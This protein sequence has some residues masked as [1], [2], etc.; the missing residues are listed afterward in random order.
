MNN[1]KQL[2]SIILSAVLTV[3]AI[4]AFAYSDVEEGSWYEKSVENASEKG[5]FAGYEDGTF[6]PE[7]PVS[8]A[9]LAE[10]LTRMDSGKKAE[11]TSSSQIQG[12]ENEMTEREKMT[13]ETYNR[14]FDGADIPENISESELYSIVNKVIYGDIYN[15]STLD[16][17]EREMISLTVLTANGTLTL[18]KSH[19]YSALNAGLSADEITETLYQ[20]TPYIGAAKALEAVGVANEVFNEKGISVQSASTTTDDSR[21]EAGKSAQAAIFGHSTGSEY[22]GTRIAT[23]Y[24]PDF[25]FGDFYTREVLSVQQREIITFCCL[26]AL[27]GCDSQIRSHITANNNVGNNREH[28]LN[29]VTTCMLYIGFPRSL[30][31]ISAINEILPAESEAN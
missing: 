1:K 9:E 28:L 10:I 16:V 5:W 17:K 21:W 24:L 13:K 22:S 18:L 11:N 6:R 20:C 25:C 7:N 29:V 19:I 15:D 2:I 4:P 27:G 14:L 26:A 31:A 12:D 8:R 23:N 30:N 3:S